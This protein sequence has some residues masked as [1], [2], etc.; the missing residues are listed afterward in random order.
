MKVV[1][2]DINDVIPYDNN[3]RKNK[4]AVAAVAKSLEEFGWQQPIVVDREGIIIVGHTRYQAAIELGMS[5]VPVLIAKDLDDEQVRAYRIAD[6]KS[7]EYAEWDFDKLAEEVNALADADYDLSSLCMTQG[8][9]DDLAALSQIADFADDV[10][11]DD[12]DADAAPTDLPYSR[13][14]EAPIYEPSAEPPDVDTLVETDKYDALYDEIEAA[15]I[16]EDIAY[17]LQQAATRHMRFDF[18]RIADF[19]AHADATVQDLMERSALVIIDFDKAIE[20]GF[21]EMSEKLC[22]LA[23]EAYSDA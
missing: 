8:E 20:N 3:P 9:L 2:R 16:P 13:K 6:N 17:F 11:S 7:G 15:D 23:G 21:V 19:Y 18:R 1:N 10:V 22:T 12:S 5:K 4:K 14:I